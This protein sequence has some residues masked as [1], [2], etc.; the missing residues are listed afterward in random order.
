MPMGS[1]LQLD[2][3][4][5]LSTL[6]LEPGEA[7]IARALQRYGCYVVDSSSGMVLYA[8]N[9]TLLPGGSNPYPSS[10]SNGLSRE[11]VKRMR[12]VDPP[13]TPTYDD[14]TAISQPHT[15]SRLD[16]GWGHRP[17]SAQDRP[18]NAGPIMG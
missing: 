17:P 3:S 9:D 4:L 7:V 6:P 13:P 12:V 10:W 5:D 1:R 14:R 2:P 18:W 16:G 11:L 8:Q 15:N